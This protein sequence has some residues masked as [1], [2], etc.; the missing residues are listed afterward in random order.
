MLRRCL[1]FEL[2]AR[3]KNLGDGSNCSSSM[4]LQ[5]DE[6]MTTEDKQLVP[7][8]P[9]SDSSR[10]ILPGIGL[11]LNALAISS[12]DNKNIRIDSLS[13]GRYLSLPGSTASFHSPKTT[14]DPLHESLPSATNERDMVAVENGVSLAEDASQTSA[15]LAGEEYNQSSPKKKRHVHLTR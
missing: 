9:S 7:L 5:S 3:R 12:Q 11:H 6:K 2:V 10:Q 1:D 15:Y 8:K 13:N 14:E 4:I